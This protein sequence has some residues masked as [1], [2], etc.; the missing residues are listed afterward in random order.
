MPPGDF[1]GSYGIVIEICG[2][3]DAEDAGEID[4]L[5]IGAEEFG[6]GPVDGLEV[7]EIVTGDEL[8]GEPRPGCRRRS[9]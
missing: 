1:D 6:E 9:G 2:P 3:R 7:P 5:G 8:L 4:G